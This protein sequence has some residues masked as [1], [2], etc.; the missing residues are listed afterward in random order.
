MRLTD[1][2]IIDLVAVLTWLRSDPQ[3][4]IASD[5]TAWQAG[6]RLAVKCGGDVLDRF[7]VTEQQVRERTSKAS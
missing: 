7:L 1:S 2:D 6:K 3:I 5:S 4:R